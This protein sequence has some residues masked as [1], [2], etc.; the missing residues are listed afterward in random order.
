MC[1]LELASGKAVA[2]D[3]E[4][5]EYIDVWNG[6]AKYKEIGRKFYLVSAFEH[7]NSIKGKQKDEGIQTI[8]YTKR[9]LQGQ[10]ELLNSFD[11][12]VN[13]NLTKNGGSVQFIYK[14]KNLSNAGATKLMNLYITMING[15]LEME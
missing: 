12:A 10:T 4:T 5:K 6:I 2:E 8:F 11:L 7:S 14:T 13:L 15:F 1:K 9:R 3:V